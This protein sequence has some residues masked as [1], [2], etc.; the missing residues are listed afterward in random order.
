M[1]P[2]PR[3][4]NLPI[5]GIRFTEKSKASTRTRLYL[6]LT[7]G[8]LS[9]DGI[10]YFCCGE[11]ISIKENRG[12][13]RKLSRTRDEN[14]VMFIVRNPR[15]TAILYLYLYSYIPSVMENLRYFF[16]DD[17]PDRMVK[18][19]SCSFPTICTME[20]SALSASHV[21][22]VMKSPITLSRLVISVVASTI[23]QELIIYST[24]T[25]M[26]RIS[27]E[28]RKP[29]SIITEMEKSEIFSD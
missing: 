22:P 24:I 29:R 11:F 25:D 14:N 2:I 28:Y 9:S 1:S 8:L 4:I 26:S 17:V 21:S 6:E 18:T 12:N 10:V 20:K 5:S 19:V 3:Y 13:K 15:D 7:A 27:D 16:D 23:I